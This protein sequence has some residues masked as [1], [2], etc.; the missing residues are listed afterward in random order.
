MSAAL[1]TT[2]LPL[3]ASNAKTS[4]GALT[5]EIDWIHLVIAKFGAV[6]PRPDAAVQPNPAVDDKIFV[7]VVNREDDHTQPVA[8]LDRRARLVNLTGFAKVLPSH[9]HIVAVLDERAEMAAHSKTTCR[10]LYPMVNRNLP[11]L[12]ALK[13]A[14]VQLMVCSQ[15]PVA[16]HRPNSAVDPGVTVTLSALT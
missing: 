6:Q 1:T 9:V 8:S 14:G 11:I 3:V 16:Q 12:Q 5:A 15:A 2:A 10:E 7:D 4:S 13:K